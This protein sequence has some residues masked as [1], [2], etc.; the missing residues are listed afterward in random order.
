MNCYGMTDVGRKREKNE[1]NFGIYEIAENALLL[2]VCDGMGGEVGGEIASSMA[3]ASFVDEIDNQLDGRI[4]NGRL[5]LDDPDVDVPMMLESAMNNA[6]FEVWQRS[7]GD[8]SLK[9]MGTTLVGAFVIK[10]A[11]LSAWSI[12][13][14]DSRLYRVRDEKM[15][16]L[17]RDHSY[18]QFL[19]DTGK[20]S[21]AEAERRHDK[22]IITK[23]VGISIQATPDI[24]KLDV[25]S[26]DMLLLC[27][28]GLS[29]MLTSDEICGIC[30]K[31]DSS[32][33][34]RVHSLVSLAN[35]A[36]G[37]DNITVVIAEL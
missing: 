30:D 15:T 31:R 3:L 33:E 36:G 34:S 26:E 4:E 37:D 10:D 20:I 14:G 2:I 25:E 12:N 5:T 27:S 35:D 7:H 9:G 18:V 32:L 22:N 8:I 21:S 23:A 24:V 1:D 28:D 29:G 16:Q 13:L 11:T 6:N 17:T 19:V